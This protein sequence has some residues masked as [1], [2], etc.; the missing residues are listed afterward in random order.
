MIIIKSKREIDIM[1]EAAKVT[2]EILRDIE[3][4]IKPG[5]TTHAID[6][7]V[8]E[9]ILHYKMKPTF[10][11]FGGFPAASWVSVND[12][13]VHVI[14]SRDRVLKEGDIGS[15]DTGA[16]YK[17]YCSD[18]AR[19]YAVGEIS[20]EAR[21]LID[22]TKQSFFEWVKYG[23][24]GY[25]L[26][27]I[28]HSVQEYAESNGF[29]VIREY[30]GHGI[31]R[32]LHEDPQV[33]NYGD[34]HTGPHLKEGMVLA[35]EPMITQ[36]SYGTRVLGNDWTVVTDDGLLAAHYENTVVITDGEPELLTLI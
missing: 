17:G 8:E 7:F 13:V 34:A 12:D 20:D 36:G 15:V 4:F 18:A 27:D 2:G 30:L 33:P 21:K 35:I 10:I 23:M 22:V 5:M 32:D 26:H 31:G 11:G 6:N 25:R 3:G 19:T 16:T 28:G 24:V 9:R 14:P 29:G 1:R